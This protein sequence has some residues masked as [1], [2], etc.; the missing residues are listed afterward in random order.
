M[1]I[2]RVVITGNLGADP[3]LRKTQSGT[4]VLSLRLAVNDRRKNPQT[5]EWGDAVNWVG[6]TMFGTRA[7][8]VANYLH[9]GSKIGVDGKLRYSEWERDG[10][11]RSTLEVV[12]DDIELLSPRQDAQGGAYGAQ[13]RQAGGYGYGVGNAPQNAPQQ[14]QGGYQQAPQQYQQQAQAAPQ[15]ELVPSIYEEDIPFGG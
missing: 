3:E 11:K 12:A 10:Q 7:E 13:Q 4:G 6:V 1:S 9:K 15:V 8:S 5:G 14:P 2:N